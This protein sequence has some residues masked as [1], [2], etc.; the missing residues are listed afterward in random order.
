MGVAWRS[1]PCLLGRSGQG[2]SARA[3][4]SQARW[5]VFVQK[6]PARRAASLHAEASPCSESKVLL[7]IFFASRRVSHE[8]VA[9]VIT[10]H[11][12]SAFGCSEEFF[13]AW[14][15]IAAA[16]CWNQKVTCEAPSV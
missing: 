10:L 1:L 11:V 6:H 9:E 14:P 15:W 12:C 2:S 8:F 13:S 4:E 7:S 3:P 16:L 5:P